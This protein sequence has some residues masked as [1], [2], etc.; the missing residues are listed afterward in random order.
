MPEPL[1]PDTDLA[2]ALVG[3][4]EVVPQRGLVQSVV[5]EEEGGDRVRIVLQQA[6]VSQERQTPLRLTVE[7]DS[8]T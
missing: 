8:G 2:A 1:I 5:R 6:V 4:A 3:A 7:P